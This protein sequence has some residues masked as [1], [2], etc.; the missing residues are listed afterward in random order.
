MTQEISEHTPDG[1][2][3][4]R[5]IHIKIQAIAG[6]GELKKAPLPL[7][8][9]AMWRNALKTDVAF[10]KKAKWENLYRS[11]WSSVGDYKEEENIFYSILQNR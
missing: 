9:D 5:K 6:V 3:M 4:V 8:L 11:I 10:G 7:K 1:N 2:D